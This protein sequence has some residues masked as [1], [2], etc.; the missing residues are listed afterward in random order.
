LQ[1]INKDG[2]IDKNDKRNTNCD[3]IIDYFVVLILKN[4]SIFY[5]ILLK[6]TNFSYKSQK[7]IL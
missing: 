3:F 7:D 2:I 1:S 6:M 4:I 5:C